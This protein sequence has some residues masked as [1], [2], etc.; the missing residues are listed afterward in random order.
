MGPFPPAKGLLGEGPRPTAPLNRHVAIPPHASPSRLNAHM[1]IQARG[2]KGAR[3]R[4][5]SPKQKSPDVKQKRRPGRVLRP[6]RL[7]R[8]YLDG[9]SR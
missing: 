9:G 3:G 7:E 2:G 8:S 4:Q 6:G 5:G 1:R